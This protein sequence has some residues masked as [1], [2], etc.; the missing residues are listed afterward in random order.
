MGRVGDS[1]DNALAEAMHGLQKKVMIH[2]SGPQK[3]HY[4][5]AMAKAAKPSAGR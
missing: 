2:R 4:C 1:Y 3:F 5:I